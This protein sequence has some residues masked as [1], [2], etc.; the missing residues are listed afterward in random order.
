MNAQKK[1]ALVV[2]DSETNRFLLGA[3]LSKAN[4]TIEYAED[5]DEAV[6]KF[7][8]FQPDVVFIDQIMPRKNGSEALKEMRQNNP[9]F[10]GILLSAFSDPEEIK[11]IFDFSGAEEFMPKPFET[12]K[13]LSMLK[14]Y[15]L[16]E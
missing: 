14:K 9:N 8:K 6:D 7:T 16:I 3:I 11:K 2:D 4:L 12:P 5:G 1:K 15:H 10:I 13:I